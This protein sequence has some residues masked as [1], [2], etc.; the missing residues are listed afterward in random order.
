MLRQ[1]LVLRHGNALHL[2]GPLVLADDG[3]KAPVDKHPESRFVPPLHPPLAVSQHLR[4]FV[5]PMAAGSAPNTALLAQGRTPAAE[6]A[7]AVAPVPNT[8]KWS[9]LDIF[10][11]LIWSYS[12][13]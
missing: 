4:T 9:R 11:G 13:V 1:L 2:H 6:P 3:I 10:G 12:F 7:R 8:R 5:G